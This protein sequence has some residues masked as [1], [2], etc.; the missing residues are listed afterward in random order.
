MR[1]AVTGA[2]GL[3]GRHLTRALLERGDQIVPLSRSNGEVHGVPTVAWDPVFDDFPAAAARGVDAVVNLAGASVADGR[4]TRERQKE[5]RTSRVI[6][7]TRIA[8]ALAAGAGPRVLVSGSATGYYGNRGD[9]VLDESSAPGDDFLA[10]TAL[11]WEAAA[12][13]AE[14]GGVRVAISRTG[15]VLARDGGVLPRLATM[16]RAGIA[17]PIGGGRQWVPWVGIDDVVGMILAALDDETWRGPFN[18]VAPEAVPQREVATTLGRVLGRPALVPTPAIA[19][20]GLMGGSAALV[21]D[22]QRCTPAAARAHGYAW[23]SGD[24][25]ECL[26][27]LLDPSAPG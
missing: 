11:A 5:I 13:G 22:G 10:H 15:M 3:I 18:N 14:S 24:L 4:W 1:V 7:T 9:E 20:R 23:I 19:I 16:T 26:E 8:E 6:T 17:G 2:T 25:R 21:L 27:T 12:R